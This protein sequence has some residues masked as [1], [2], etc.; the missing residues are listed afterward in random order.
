M[1]NNQQV[2]LATMLH[3]VRKSCAFTP[4][5]G[6]N[7]WIMNMTHVK[8]CEAHKWTYCINIVKTSTIGTALESRQRI[9]LYIFEGR[10]QSSTGNKQNPTSNQSYRCAEAR[11]TFVQVCN[12]CV[13]KVFNH[14]FEVVKFTLELDIPNNGIAKNTHRPKLQGEKYLF[15]CGWLLT[16]IVYYSV[17]IAVTCTMRNIHTSYFIS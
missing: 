17:R 2:G 1:L 4:K 3:F 6:W 8:D 15:F 9:D 10:M 11:S 13:F 5:S 16:W 7:I 12:T 14:S